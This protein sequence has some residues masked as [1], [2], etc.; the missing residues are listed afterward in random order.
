MRV[1]LD[2]NVWT[3]IGE[4]GETTSFEQL[5]DELALDIVIPP[6]ILLEAAR[7][8]VPDIRDQ[9]VRA[10]T[11]RRATRVHPLPEARLEADEVAA[12]IRR[13]RPSWARHSPMT[14]RLPPLEAFWTRRIW[15]IAAR[16]PAEIAQRELRTPTPADEQRILQTQLENKEAAMEAGFRFG[17][18]GPWV[19]LAGQTGSQVAGWDGQRFEYWRYG[20]AIVWWYGLIVLPG[21]R[22]FGG[23]TTL[24]DWLGPWVRSDLIA[25]DRES[26]N[27]LWYYETDAIELPRNWMRE[28]IPWA[29]LGTKVGKGNP[30]DMQHAS[31]LFDADVFV[32]A[33]RRYAASLE[34][35]RTWAPVE[36]AKVVR[37]PG[38][39]STVTALAA[40][41]R[42]ISSS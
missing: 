33:D 25:R 39:G 18:T 9:I 34:L 26:W 6:S 41:L 28:V 35:V 23:D 1:I 5:E 37:I 16:D 38:T 21:R 36:F 29:Q 30:R 11:R 20:V 12:E 2:T 8:P 22:A 3:Y 17:K 24:A 42:A 32:T 31:Y 4:R 40:A 27:R 7:T 15:Q 14:S 19:D 13:L 10:M